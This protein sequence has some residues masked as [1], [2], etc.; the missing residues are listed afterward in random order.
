M[1]VN[2]I[3]TNLVII[4]AVITLINIGDIKSYDLPDVWATLLGAWVLFTILSCV[5]W[6]IYLIWS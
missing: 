5:G 4:G 2:I 3:L 6:V 1:I